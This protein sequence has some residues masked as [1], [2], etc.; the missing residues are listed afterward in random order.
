MGCFSLFSKEVTGDPNPTNFAIQKMKAI[1][2]YVVVWVKYPDCTNFNGNKNLVYK[3]V[4]ISVLN[5]TKILDPH[6]TKGD[7]SPI[8]RFRPGI[9]GWKNACGFCRLLIG[10]ADEH[11]T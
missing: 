9:Q 7:L 4:S 10:A 5:T 8:A 6:F 3:N 2:P 11:K 1:G